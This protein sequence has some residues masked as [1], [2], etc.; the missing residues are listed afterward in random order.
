VPI[1]GIADNLLKNRCRSEV[2]FLMFGN[3]ERRL[4]RR[5]EIH[6][7]ALGDGWSNGRTHG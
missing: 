6:A 5:K 4:K 1:R 7:T 3:G 2:I